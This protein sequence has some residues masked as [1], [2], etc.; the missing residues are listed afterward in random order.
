MNI[1]NYQNIF[2][3]IDGGATKTKGVLF[4]ISGSTLSSLTI[5][6][7]NL[8][9]YKEAAAQR[10]CNLIKSLIETSD[11][12]LESINCIGLGI[13]GS[14]DKDGRDILFKELDRIK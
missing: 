7:S 6:G 12:D 9:I 8:N 2:I 3:G 13:A 14:S 11:I 5:R 1:E 10:I 4:D